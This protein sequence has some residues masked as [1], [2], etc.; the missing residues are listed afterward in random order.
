L[1]SGIKTDLTSCVKAL[2]EMG[3]M[4]AGER[5]DREREKERRGSERYTSLPLNL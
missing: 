5:S 4:K 3:A 1:S 2:T